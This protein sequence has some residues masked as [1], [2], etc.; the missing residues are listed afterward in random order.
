MTKA[1]ESEA[2]PESENNMDPGIRDALDPEV[3]R[4]PNFKVILARINFLASRNS[5]GATASC[6]DFRSECKRGDC[7]LI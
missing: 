6:F 4:D 7:E 1:S 3:C 5:I 2:K